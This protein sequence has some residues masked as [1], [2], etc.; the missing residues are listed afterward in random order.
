MC[1]CGTTLSLSLSV[2]VSSCEARA[3]VVMSAVSII[4]LSSPQ[5]GDSWSHTGEDQLVL[6]T[7]GQPRMVRTKRLPLLRQQGDTPTR[8]LY[9]QVSAYFAEFRHYHTDPYGSKR[10]L[11]LCKAV[12]RLTPERWTQLH[13][14]ARPARGTR[15]VAA[16]RER[17]S[18]DTSRR[19]LCARFAL[20][21]RTLR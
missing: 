9:A 6:S 10:D 20:C 12:V 2:T 13:C 7:H 18:V 11:H 16:N 15:C 21:A 8:V 4:P 19:R 5:W 17:W 3:D 1:S 14:S